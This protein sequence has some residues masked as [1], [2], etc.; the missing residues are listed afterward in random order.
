MI[1][2]FVDALIAAPAPQ[3]VLAKPVQDVE[4]LVESLFNSKP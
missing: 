3:P 1:D 2:G 4:T